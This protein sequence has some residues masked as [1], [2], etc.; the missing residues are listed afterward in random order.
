MYECTFACLSNGRRFQHRRIRCD[1]MRVCWWVFYV[2]LLC[3][4]VR[5]VL[6]LKLVIFA[7]IRLY[8]RWNYPDAMSIEYQIKIEWHFNLHVPF[9]RK[10]WICFTSFTM[11]AAGYGLECLV[12]CSSATVFRS[13]AVT[14]SP[15]LANFIHFSA[16]NLSCSAHRAQPAFG[17]KASS[18]LNIFFFLF[19]S[20]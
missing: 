5:R 12:C 15:L 19:L 10:T 3:M 16:S 2:D 4:R 14:R 20:F 7:F 9:I 13:V 11:T 17:W 18:W 8:S 1:A 6:F